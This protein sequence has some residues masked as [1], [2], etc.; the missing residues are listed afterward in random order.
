M[1]QLRLLEASALQAMATHTAA[2]ENYSNPLP[3]RLCRSTPF[4]LTDKSYYSRLVLSYYG[5]AGF[6]S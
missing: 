6:Q 3:L 4:P 2:R 1:F 5:G